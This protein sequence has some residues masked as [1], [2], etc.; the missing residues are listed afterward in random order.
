MFNDAS[1]SC[2]IYSSVGYK[3]YYAKMGF[4]DNP[5]NYIVDIHLSAVADTWTYSK[6]NTGDKQNFNHYVSV[7]YIE[8][9]PADI[10][11]M[12]YT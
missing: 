1:R 2:K 5:Q 6:T 11:S 7:Q 4:T 8:I 10:S 12:S 9:S 3:V